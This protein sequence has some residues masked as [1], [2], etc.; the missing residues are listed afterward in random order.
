VKII[1]LEIPETSLKIRADDIRRVDITLHRSGE[2]SYTYQLEPRQ[3]VAR[4]IYTT[5]ELEREP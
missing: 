4:E 2:Q 3:V 5:V 1:L